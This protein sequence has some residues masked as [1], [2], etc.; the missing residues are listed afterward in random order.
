[1][2]ALANWLFDMACLI[3]CIAAVGSRIDWRAVV[4]VYALT[5]LIAV[6]P[7]TPGGLGVVEAGLAALLVCYGTPAPSAIAT[8]V[9]YRVLTFWALVPAGWVV[10]WR[11]DKQRAA[12]GALG[13]P[14]G[15]NTL[16][17][18][19]PAGHAIGSSPRQYQFLPALRPHL[20]VNTEPVTV[21]APGT[22]NQTPPGRLI[23]QGG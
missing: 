12:L 17:I 20:K 3:A 13:R 19:A 22:P 23:T 1:M 6:L 4:V 15:E 21:L 16:S 2:L 11:L 7:F 14:R 5:Q 10:W 18:S 9:V 8:V